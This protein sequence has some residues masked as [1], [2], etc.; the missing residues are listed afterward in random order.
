MPYPSIEHTLQRGIDDLGTTLTQSQ[1]QTLLSYLTE[2][3]EWNRAFNLTAIRDLEQM[4]IRHLLDS[5]PIV[6]HVVGERVLDI[7]S[8]AGLPGIPLAIAKP[9]MTV[10]LL[11]GNGKKTR[12]LTH[13]KRHLGLHNVEVHH[14]RIENHRPNP[15]YD[16]I[17]ARAFASTDT[18][19]SMSRPLIHRNS[20]VLAMTGKLDSGDN[21]PDHL[22][23]VLAQCHVIDVPMLDESRHILEFR[24]SE[25]WGE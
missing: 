3:D 6:E 25:S 21:L 14:E 16:T 7:G 10:A 24:T 18:L 13:V 23:F 11:D 1:T 2:L 15:P 5:L 4:V 9:E 19:L 22:P 8:G 20:R 17:T 12:F